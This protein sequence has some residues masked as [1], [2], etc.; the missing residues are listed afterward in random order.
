MRILG[1]ED[2]FEGSF[3]F[4]VLLFFLGLSVLII[5][6]GVRLLQGVYSVFM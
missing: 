3:V 5:L 6:D 4:E 2:D 1:C